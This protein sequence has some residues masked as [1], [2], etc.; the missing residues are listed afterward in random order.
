MICDSCKHEFCWI[1][2]LSFYSKKHE[3]FRFFCEAMNGIVYNDGYF[4]EMWVKCIWLRFLAF[5]LFVIFVPFLFIA[6]SPI[7]AIFLGPCYAYKELH[8]G[9]SCIKPIESAKIRLLLCIPC[10]I[11]CF[12]L[13]IAISPFALPAYFIVFL[14]FSLMIMI[15]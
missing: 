8:Y 14:V 3:I 13:I 7:F 2:S 10:S 5:F 1:C 11:S 4:E 12:L 6:V 9:L 15:E